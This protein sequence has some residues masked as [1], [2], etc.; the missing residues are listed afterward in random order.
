MLLLKFATVLLCW[1]NFHFVGKDSS[2]QSQCPFMTG[3]EGT[4][5][6]LLPWSLC[7]SSQVDHFTLQLRLGLPSR[8]TNSVLLWF[9]KDF[10]S[11]WSKRK[12]ELKKKKKNLHKI[13]LRQTWTFAVHCGASLSM[14]SASIQ[15]YR[16]SSTVERPFSLNVV[17]K[18]LIIFGIS[19]EKGMDVYLS[20][21]PFDKVCHVAVN[22][23]PQDFWEKQTEPHEVKPNNVHCPPGFSQTRGPPLSPCNEEQW[24]LVTDISEPSCVHAILR[25]K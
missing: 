18:S 22:S 23:R 12:T 24:M 13:R 1:R 3:Q 20:F 25:V 16:T 10:H 14:K 9:L 19:L 11:T 5:S 6:N 17:G 21:N 15:L 2:A 7:S 8:R 4:F